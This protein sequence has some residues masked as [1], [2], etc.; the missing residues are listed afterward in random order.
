MRHR[1]QKTLD[2]GAFGDSFFV[3]LSICDRS[4]CQMVPRRSSPSRRRSDCTENAPRNITFL[5]LGRLI[6]CPTWPIPVP[7]TPD[8]SM[9]LP[10]HPS[11]SPRC[12]SYIEFKYQYQ[13]RCP[14]I[15]P[16]PWN[17]QRLFPSTLPRPFDVH[18]IS[19]SNININTVY[20]NVIVHTQQY[21]NTGCDNRNTYKGIYIY[22]HITPGH[23]L[24]TTTS[25]S[26]VQ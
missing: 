2:L 23:E 14:S 5:P 4:C 22:I 15:S 20:M 12:S 7:D 16:T 10:I 25:A 13:Y 8:P 11:P 17:L 3:L 1:L 6:V 18:P 24:P 19:N 9:F 21:W 26:T